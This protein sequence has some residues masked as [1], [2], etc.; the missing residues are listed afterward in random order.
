MLR[1]YVLP[2]AATRVCTIRDGI[3]KYEP[4]SRGTGTYGRHTARHQRP[5]SKE[6][7]NH[8]FAFIGAGAKNWTAEVNLDCHDLRLF[9]PIERKGIRRLATELVKIRQSLSAGQDFDIDNILPNA[10]FVRSKMKLVAGES[11]KKY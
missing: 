11:R 10:D 1:S 2:S 4:T 7:E 3:Y 5:N 9:Q 6:I 8:K